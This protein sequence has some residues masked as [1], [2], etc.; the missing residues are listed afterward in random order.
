METARIAKR[1]EIRATPEQVFALISDP[2]S[3]TALLPGLIGIT[4]ISPLPL[5]K[6][7]SFDYKYRM[8]GTEIAGTW[9][10]DEIKP[11]RLYRSHT[12]GLSESHWTQ[13]VS[14]SAEGSLYALT[15]DYTIP[16]GLVRHLVAET[17][18]AANDRDMDEM[19][20]NLK[21]VL[22]RANHS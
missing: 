16:D 8:V 19:I 7:S 2:T 20:T 17:I 22:E 6:G 12:K 14:P 11:P 1:I 10:V 3:F 4:N 21:K 15:I 5:E 18:I 9:S 13:E